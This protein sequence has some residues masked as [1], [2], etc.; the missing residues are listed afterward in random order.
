MLTSS[1]SN[2]SILM[3]TAR[4][5]QFGSAS[6]ASGRD[7]VVCGTMATAIGSTIVNDVQHYPLTDL[8]GAGTRTDDLVRHN[9]NKA[10][11]LTN[12]TA[13]IDPVS[14]PTHHRRRSSNKSGPSLLSATLPGSHK[15][16]VG[17]ARKTYTHAKNRLKRLRN[18][19]SSS[20]FV[21]PP[22]GVGT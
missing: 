15:D 18:Q 19:L 11:M 4:H 9:N 13:E 10:A 2:A 17:S 12:L 21:H 5:G 16:Q 1:G 22:R 3:V 7:G 14:S 8:L 20:L 6:G